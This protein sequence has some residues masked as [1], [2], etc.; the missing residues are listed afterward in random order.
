MRIHVTDRTNRTKQLIATMLL[1][2]VDYESSEIWL[3]SPWLKNVEFSGADLGHH[4]SLFGAHLHTVT[5]L[6]LLKKLGSRHELHVVIK[7][8]HELVKLPL[9]QRIVEL[10]KDR[11]AL[12]QQELDFELEQSVLEM[13]DQNLSDL[14]RDFLN[15]ADTLLLS[16][17]LAKIGAQVYF[18]DA[19]H[20]KLLWLPSGALFGSAN[21][22]NGG[23]SYNAELIAEA[24]SDEDMHALR[25]AAERIKDESCPRRK[26]NFADRELVKPKYSLPSA[27]F[28][29]CA[30]DPSLAA[31]RTF[32][33]LLEYLGGLYR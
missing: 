6:D 20:A 13:L 27:T 28:F 32:R 19:L 3:I 1:E 30:N 26:Y 33:P 14:S 17:E 10:H 15:H 5:L 21:F 9:L 29:A 12:V 8:P 22:T 7:P 16:E 11:A 23:L 31:D 18:R 2:A 25:L 4:R 24:F